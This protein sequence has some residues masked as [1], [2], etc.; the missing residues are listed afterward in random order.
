MAKKI[1]FI[2]F[3]SVWNLY[4]QNDTLDK[5]DPFHRVK[6]P[7]SD[8]VVFH[9]ASSN[10]QFFKVFYHQKVLDTSQYKVNFTTS[11]LVLNNPLFL[12]NLPKDSIEI[13]FKTYPEFLTKTYVGYDVSQIF[14]NVNPKG[15]LPVENGKS[16]IKGTPFAGL[17]TQG[18]LI[19]GVTIGNNQDAVLNSSLDLKIEGKLASNVSLKA[20][21]NDTNIPIQENGY[22][23]ELKDIDRIYMELFGPKWNVKAGDIFLKDSTHYFLNFTKKVQGVSVG[24]NTEKISVF[25]SGALVKGRY[26]TFQFTG[27]EANQGPYK[28]QGAN[29]ELYIFIINGSERVYING[30]IQTSGENKDYTMD[31]NTGEITFSPTNP[32]T[33]DMRISIE[34]QY[35]ER[36]FTRFVTHNSATFHNDKFA[37]G[38]VFF[39]EGD[40]KNQTID[41]DLTDEQKLLL[42]QAGN[43][44]GL[45]YVENV[46]ETEPDA[47]KILYR[48]TTLNGLEI[49]EFSTDSSQTLYQVGFTYF[50]PGL[51]DYSVQDYLVIGKK[52]HYVGENQ[53]DYKAV[54]PLFAPSSLQVLVLHAAYNPNEK[55]SL[56]V[57]LAYSDNDNNLFSETVAQDQKAPALK[58]DVQQTLWD[59]KWKATTT[60]QYDFLHQNFN[61]VEGTYDLEFDRDWNAFQTTGNQSLLKSKLIFENSTI[62]SFFYQF[63]NLNF[64]KSY[65]GNKHSLGADLQFDNLYINQLSSV[66][67]TYG[68]SFNSRFLR[69]ETTLK[70]LK[71]NW[72]AETRFYAESNRIK[73]ADDFS[74]APNTFQSLQEKFQFGIGDSTKVYVKS[75]LL[76]QQ[77]DSVRNNLLSQVNTS[78][79]IFIKTQLIENTT[80]NLQVY[81]NYRTI[82]YNSLGSKSTFNS[83]ITYRQLLFDKLW[84]FQS[85]YQNTSGQIAKQEYTYFETEPG[86]GFY[87]WIDYNEN[88]VKEPDEFEVAQFADQANYLRITLP[89]LSY[90]PTQEAKLSMNLVLNTSKWSNNTGYRKFLSHWYNQFNVVAH[91]S[92]LKTNAVFNYNP[93]DFSNMDVLNNQFNIR[94]QLVFNRGKSQY[95]TS[96]IFGK[97]N[98]KIWQSFGSIDQDILLHQ[99]QFQHLVKK[100][101]QIG[102]DS[103]ITENKTNNEFYVNRNFLLNSIKL[104][105]NLTYFFTKSHWIKSVYEWA[106]KE[107]AILQMERLTIH[108]LSFNY[109]YTSPQETR[110]SADFNLL[111]NSFEGN[112]NSA[113]GYQMLEG[114]QPGKNLTWN[115]LWS[116]KINSFLFLNLN[117]NGRAN[118][119]S[120]TIH[121]GNVQL[122]ANF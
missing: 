94:N 68:S 40:L 82:Q 22:S 52:M 96:Y 113:V 83:R 84:S 14:P 55:S 81:A 47:N 27:Q 51:G 58:V 59:K 46:V 120:R 89:N 105:P 16:P 54:I 3:F 29:G 21:I 73:N 28:L 74:F 122:R 64:S 87:T 10:P 65:T 104:K 61:N 72:W 12:N 60:L 85:E 23:H 102:M 6:L 33:S 56:G 80:S 45:V 91:N 66:L 86:Q 38:A 100:N 114:L 37:F 13:Q 32:I 8:T 107:N 76:F 50:G 34:Y 78:K 39:K 99:I 26:T 57:E 53:G 17:E 97:T 15:L 95:T 112:E 7:I 119:F 30:I 77:N 121:N 42:A 19:R 108:K 63:N 106:E 18:N 67:N 88:G 44:A 70:I 35:S 25:N 49:F 111:K 116:K 117:Y 90:V 62:G 92:K 118:E 20:R 101:L 1:V 48:K 9:K 24:I 69:N 43:D 41:R 115:V 5:S 2:L 71:K 98:Q 31:Y 4:S 11:K 79:T 110:F 109:Q 103:E 75:G 93:F 36:N